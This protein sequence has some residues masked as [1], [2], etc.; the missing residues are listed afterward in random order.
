V[1]R[2]RRLVGVGIFVAAGLVL[3]G[4]SGIPRSSGVNEGGE[5]AGP[6]SA[7]IEFLPAGPQIDADPSTILRGFIE[8]ASSPQNDFAIARQFLTAGASES[9]NPSVVTLIDSG[10]RP[11]SELSDTT[12]TI[13]VDA[14]AVLDAEGRF[15]QQQTPLQAEMIYSFEQRAG[16]WRI[17]NLPPGIVI[18]RTTFGQVFRQTSLYF[19]SPDNRRLVP[20]VRWFPSRASTTTRIVKSLLAGPAPWLSSTGAARTAFPAGTRLIADAV[21]VQNGVAVV[22][23]DA[24]SLRASS[25]AV[26]LMKIQL[27]A[28]LTQAS[29]VNDVDLQI[30]G[31]SQRNQATS[32]TLAQMLPSGDG[33]PVVIRDGRLGKLSGATVEPLL[34]LS[35]RGVD[36]TAMTAGT[37]SSDLLSLA[38]LS[39]DGVWIARAGGAPSLLDSRSG[40]IAPALDDYGHVWT[41]PRDSPTEVV[42]FSAEGSQN[43]VS[44]PWTEASSIVALRLSLDGQRAVALVVQDDRARVVVSSVARDELGT[45]TA[46][47]APIDLVAPAGYPVDAVWLDA[48][49]VAVAG[50]DDTGRGN[51]LRQV[52]G[53]ESVSYTGVGAVAGLAG[54]SAVVHLSALSPSGVLSQPRGTSSWL[55]SATGVT[56]LLT[57]Q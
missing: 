26:S 6:A 47:G 8:A 41:V 22:D 43:A 17:S 34:G 11:I 3:A 32:V 25:A 16:Q 49:T 18:D 30:L 46:L 40:L 55:V 14:S 9:W 39:S 10:V 35:T 50:A 7:E 12:I 33:S 48:I 13:G 28:S 56:A 44:V 57:V 36:L 54:G 29:N 24:E 51:I 52:V 53:G 15:T 23:L 20:D 19:L 42:A 38:L 1:R 21:P 5:I 31:T 4:C 2:A 27:L 37:V 45:P